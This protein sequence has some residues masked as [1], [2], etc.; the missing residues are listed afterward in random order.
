[1]TY[2]FEKKCVPQKG[3]KV[4]NLKTHNWPLLQTAACF[5]SKQMSDLSKMTQVMLFFTSNHCLF[6]ICIFLTPYYATCV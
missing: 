6:H 1:M 4:L 2:I 5:F 3:N